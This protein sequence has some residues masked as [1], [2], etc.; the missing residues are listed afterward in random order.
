VVFAVLLGTLMISLTIFALQSAS[1]FSKSESKAYTIL[2]RLSE[3]QKLNDVLIR[4][5]QVNLRIFLMKQNKEPWLPRLIEKPEFTLLLR[6]RKDL[7]LQKRFLLQKITVEYFTNIEDK[8]LNLEPRIE[9]DIKSIKENLTHLSNFRESLKMQLE[10]QTKQIKQLELNIINA[11][12]TEHHFQLLNKNHCRDSR[13]RLNISDSKSVLNLSRNNNQIKNSQ[14]LTSENFLALKYNENEYQIIFENPLINSKYEWED[15]KVQEI[16]NLKY[17]K[18]INLTDYLQ[19]I[20]NTNQN[21]SHRIN[22]NF[23]LSKYESINFNSDYS[24][25]STSLDKLHKI[26]TTP[27]DLFPSSSSNEIKLLNEKLLLNNSK[28]SNSIGKISPISLK[29]KSNFEISPEFEKKE[30]SP[31]TKNMKILNKLKN[32]K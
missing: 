10:S 12:E 16:L 8:F 22:K 24:N 6:K 15:S 7:S 13:S 2:R 27:M 17:K 25:L 4:L 3:R 20:K 31:Q 30:E 11:T 26:L 29:R 23:Q 32:I 14:F 5:I 19:L 1:T 21:I 9:G 28:Y 18:I